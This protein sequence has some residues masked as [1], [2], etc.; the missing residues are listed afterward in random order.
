MTASS[1]TEETIFGHALDL[2]AAGRSTYLDE[3]CGDDPALRSRVEALLRAHDGA[4]S[5]LEGS[6]ASAKRTTLSSLSPAEKPGTL[7]GRYKLLQKIGEG[8]CGVVWMAEQQ[9]PV[10][11]RVALKVIKLGMDTR[12]V[13]ARFEAERQALALMDH[14]NIARVLDA[15]AT[16]TGRPYFVMELVRGVP[17][18]KY[19]DENNLPT[20]ARLGLFMQVCQ[21]VQHAHQK[22]IIHRDLKP[23]N[24]LITVNDGGPVPKVIDFGIAK[25]TQGRLTDRTLFTAFEQFIGT[26][27][28][29][30]PEQAELSSVDVDT[31]SD[32]Y[33]LGVLLYELLTGQTPFDAK[34]L[35]QAGLDEIRRVIREVEPPKP[36]ARLSTLTDADRATVAKFRGTAPTHLASLLRGDLDWIVMRCLEK[37]R[38]RRYETANGLALDLQRHLSNE[39]VTARPPGTTY[40]L[41]KLIRRHRLV[42]AAGG[43]VVV[44]LLTGVIF[45]TWAFV[46]ERAASVRA[47]AARAHAD[48]LVSYLLKDVRPT[49]E[50]FGRGPLL[51]RLAREA[52]LYYDQ[53]PPELHNTAYAKNRAAALEVLGSTLAPRKDF[54]AARDACQ[55]AQALRQRALSA[56]PDDVETAV[57]LINDEWWLHWYSRAA[58][59]PM[60]MVDRWHPTA[61]SRLEGLIRRTRELWAAHP[62]NTEVANC[63]AGMLERLARFRIF[64]EDDPQQAV[65][66]FTEALNSLRDAMQ[67]NPQDASLKWQFGLISIFRSKAH[68]NAVET[69]AAAA[70]GEKALTFALSASAA[71]PGNIALF[72]MSGKAAV[73]LGARM[74]SVS[75]ERGKDAALLGRERYRILQQLDPTNTEWREQFVFTYLTEARYYQADGQYEK[76]RDSFRQF[77]AL[78]ATSEFYWYD[79]HRE[80]ARTNIDLGLLAAALGDTDT[81]RGQVISAR[82]EYQAFWSQL[83]ADG[84]DR[85]LAQLLW[86]DWEAE[87]YAA[88]ND[89]LRLEATA[90]ASLAAVIPALDPKS[91]SGSFRLR[92]FHARIF[93][94]RALLRQGRAS[95]A[96]PVLETALADLRANPPLSLEIQDDPPQDYA[97]WDA[98]ELLAETLSATGEKDQARGLWAQVLEFRESKLARQPR[99]AQWQMEFV[100][101]A[102][103]L[104]G[105]LDPAN[106]AEAA[107]RES[108]LGRAADFLRRL[109]AENRLSVRQRE[110]LPKIET[111]RPASSQPP[112]AML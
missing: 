98:Q 90:A 29:M 8:G 99:L 76:A 96:R 2:P 30:S 77:T 63:L 10:V 3:V 43:I 55:E 15:S 69:E 83:T 14:P 21:A 32:I 57:A 110:L 6:P 102:V 51:E 100:Q 104:A 64:N 47:E 56:V 75:P 31:R 106:S 1:Y 4:D 59:N 78:L 27:A 67:R 85:L 12:E 39:P 26:P 13:I 87:I 109:A 58:E 66:H 11:R 86:L 44:A 108:L 95:E 40:L 42:F 9:E 24:I 20:P 93:L 84:S 68:Q 41:Q 70:E 105:V 82:A 94:G 19:C 18:T 103:M 34:S 16:D 46:R 22:G 92:L 62:D 35:V 97:V 37:D 60:F 71:D 50:Q 91:R 48:R 54:A 17:I 5:L 52:L 81:V 23:T 111:L 25:A 89:W 7:I 107:R 73:S 65:I 101:T 38:R 74:R 61:G 33:S 112:P 49:L 80:L 88:C 45:S 36:S 28:Y 79:N 53:L 72:E